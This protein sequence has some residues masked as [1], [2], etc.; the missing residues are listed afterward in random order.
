MDSAALI[1][2]IINFEPIKLFVI[3]P[4]LRLPAGEAGKRNILIIH[5]YV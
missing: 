2:A 5:F 1:V 4:L 3:I